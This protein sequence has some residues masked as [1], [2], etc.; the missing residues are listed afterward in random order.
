MGCSFVASVCVSRVR[1]MVFR[2]TRVVVV[3]HE[4]ERETTNWTG[5]DWPGCGNLRTLKFTLTTAFS[6]L[7]YAM[8]A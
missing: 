2:A 1:D 4:G 8:R 3:E 5:P 7:L 6:F